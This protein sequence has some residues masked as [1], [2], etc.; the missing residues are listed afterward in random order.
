MP[1]HMYASPSA[2]DPAR[3]AVWAG[4]EPRPDPTAAAAV[5]LGRGVVPRRHGVP[6]AR[7]ESG[8]VPLVAQAHPARAASVTASDPEAKT[9]EERAQLPKF[10]QLAEFP[11]E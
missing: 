10:G 11:E 7:R 8:G 3:Q 1:L 5:L 6:S 4:R 9:K 2:A